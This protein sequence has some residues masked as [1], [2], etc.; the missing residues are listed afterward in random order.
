MLDCTFNPK[1]TGYHVAHHRPGEVKLY[2]TFWPIVRDRW[3]LN[4]KMLVHEEG[5]V[6][7]VSPRYIGCQFRELAQIATAPAVQ[8]ERGEQARL[9]T[10][11]PHTQR[12]P[13]PET[14]WNS[15]WCH[16]GLQTTAPR[17]SPALRVVCNSSKTEQKGGGQQ[18]GTAA[19]LLMKIHQNVCQN[20]ILRS[21]WNFKKIQKMFLQEKVF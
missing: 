19:G 7:D 10:H 3:G 14:D 9:R 20:V 4:W 16:S 12:S 17:A 1:W 11:H 15:D 21:C 8:L 13:W 18:G 5:S 2:L 6:Y